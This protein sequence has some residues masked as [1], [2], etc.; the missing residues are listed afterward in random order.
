MTNKAISQTVQVYSNISLLDS[1]QFVEDGCLAVE[2]GTIVYAGHLNDL[3]KTLSS[4]ARIDGKGA[5]VVPGFVNAHTHMS[6]SFLREI[7]HGTSEMI[8]NVFF[9]MEG[10]LTDEE[11]NLFA[12]P[13]LAGSIKSGVTTFVDHY[14]KIEAVEKAI[15]EVGARGFLAETLADLGGAMP[16]RV[17]PSSVLSSETHVSK[18][19]ALIKKILGPHAAD[20]VSQEYM[21]EIGEFAAKHG[22]PIHMH[23]SQTIKER[24]FCL[25]KYKMSPVELAK[26]CNVLGKKTLAVHLSSVSESDLEILAQSGCYVGLCPTSQVIYED[27]APLA[28][29]F[30]K[31]LPCVLGTDC[32][33]S[34]DSM[35]ILSELK[36]L[37]LFC[38]HQ[39]V[40]I[41][42]K[43]ILKTVW[44]HPA[45][46][47]G[48]KL[49]KL[50]EGFLADI[51]FLE[52]GLECEPCYDPHLQLIATLTSRHVRDV[53]VQGEFVLKDRQFTNF[54]EYAK[55]EA[56][57]SHSRVSSLKSSLAN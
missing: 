43:Q 2:N 9:P 20:T 3:P 41:D 45:E 1:Q 23:L 10:T 42:A 30:E 48:V 22:V 31:G 57:K 6:L 35:D 4:E 7:A 36:S 15:L 27:L 29:F 44:D 40:E 50:H 33:A 37:Y 24:E 47:L 12:F 18:K 39:K 19:S 34:H 17:S 38:R 54:D 46:W 16:K 25:A 14:Y 21:T 5:W 28:S 52:R 55:L 32:A 56:M 11:I 8:Q 51:V 53:L 13:S 26:A 49:G